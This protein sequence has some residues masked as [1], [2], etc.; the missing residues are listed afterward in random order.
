MEKAV[1]F[2]TSLP[3]A[4]RSHTAPA[5]EASYYAAV[6]HGLPTRPS[7]GAAQCTA[8]A[9]YVGHSSPSPPPL[10]PCPSA[11]CRPSPLTAEARGSSVLGL[12]PRSSGLGRRFG[13][14]GG[15]RS[16]HISAHQLISISQLVSK[17]SHTGRFCERSGQNSI[18]GGYEKYQLIRIS[19]S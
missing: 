2:R 12:A 10:P 1:P 11:S 8:P 4:C 19:C 6:Y 3:L 7:T 14:P 13:A 5:R 9:R 17:P 15:R 16:H 18:L